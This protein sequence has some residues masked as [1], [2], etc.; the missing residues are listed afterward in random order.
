[1]YKKELLVPNAYYNFVVNQMVIK[2][3]C[4]LS[5]WYK[6][7]VNGMPNGFIIY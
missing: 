4:Q 2:I 3:F 7:F 1:M 5:Y 6:E